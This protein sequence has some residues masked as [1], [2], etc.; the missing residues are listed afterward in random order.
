MMLKL[1]AW[2]RSMPRYFLRNDGSFPAL[3]FGGQLRWKLRH[4][5]PLL[6]WPGILAIG[7]LVV[8]LTFYLSS[9]RPK[10]AG[11]DVA[12][13]RVASAQERV[14]NSSKAADGG[15]SPREQL[16]EFYKF[17]PTEKKSPQWLEKLVVVAEKNALTLN[18]GEYKV[19]QDKAGLLMRYKI[20]LP[21]RGKYLQLR[22]FLTSLR[23]EIPIM[24][25]EN[26]QF[27]RDNIV[28]STVQ[29]KIKLVLYLVQES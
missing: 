27:E 23:T 12:Q 5:L 28:D 8:C 14:L 29:A 4:W 21:V 2:L 24:A 3:S 20:T 19:T 26:V 7:L 6:G 9:I 13:Q 17:F 22:K 11:L 18:I 15:G 25:L 10:Q 1:N 16:A